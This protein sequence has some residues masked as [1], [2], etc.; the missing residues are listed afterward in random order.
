MPVSQLLNNGAEAVFD[1]VR[2]NAHEL[3]L[4]PVAVTDFRV[5]YDFREDFAS[6]TVRLCAD[7]N[8]NVHQYQGADDAARHSEFPSPREAFQNQNTGAT[9]MKEE[10]VRLSLLGVP[11]SGDVDADF[12]AD[13]GNLCSCQI[14]G[15]SFLLVCH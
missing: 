10:K 12:F 5:F 8:T 9:A 1:R 4:E 2:T 11:G 15:S 13:T 7:H 14:R 3:V 6:T